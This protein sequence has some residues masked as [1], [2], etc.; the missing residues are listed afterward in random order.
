MGEAAT[1]TGRLV[2]A[3]ANLYVGPV[4]SD[5]AL[6]AEGDGSGRGGRERECGRCLSTKITRD[7]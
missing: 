4:R 2:V 3:W 5:D 6:R 7:Y 1:L